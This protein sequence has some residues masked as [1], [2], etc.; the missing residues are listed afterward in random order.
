MMEKYRTGC[1]RCEMTLQ[2]GW[3]LINDQDLFLFATSGFWDRDERIATYNKVKA[4]Y[5]GVDKPAF[6]DEEIAHLEST[7]DPTIGCKK[8]YCPL[9]ASTINKVRALRAKAIP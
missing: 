1:G 5:L 9:C 7:I 6:T 4:E 2:R 8:M 3:Y